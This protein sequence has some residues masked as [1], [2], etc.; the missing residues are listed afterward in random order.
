M[1]RV[2][3]LNGC[4]IFRLPSKPLSQMV[5]QRGVAD[6]K[7]DGEVNDRPHGGWLE[8][9]ANGRKGKITLVRKWSR[10]LPGVQHPD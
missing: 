7:T 8:I 4:G 6:E 9:P 3:Q 10:L 5:D 1:S 2:R